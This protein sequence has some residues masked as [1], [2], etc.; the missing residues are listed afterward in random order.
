MEITLSDG[1]V[2]VLDQQDP[3]TK[4]DGGYQGLLVGLQERLNRQTGALTLSSGDLK[5]IQK[6]AFGYGKGGWEDRLVKIF[7]RNLGARLGG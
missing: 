2:E 7:G 6:Y 5:R 3:R 4:G 1:E